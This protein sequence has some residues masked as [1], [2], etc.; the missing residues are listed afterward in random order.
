[1]AEMTSDDVLQKV[2]EAATDSAAKQY[3][4]Y[5]KT[6]VALDGK[7]QAAST[8][9][10]V[11]LGFIVAMANSGK[12]NAQLKD[13]VFLLVLALQIGAALY[14][15]LFGVLASRVRLV[16]VPYDAEAQIE[17]FKNLYAA[18]ADV[19]QSNLIAFHASRH[20][21]WKKS[22]ES[23]SQAIESKGCRVGHAQ[24]AAVA[25]AVLTVTALVVALLSK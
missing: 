23:M 21:Q 19:A 4:D 2:A 22:L 3:D 5:S 10:S 14:A 8:V 17:E 6:F 24:W 25:C 11:L 15:I 18:R 12:F 7:G 1:M 13:P 16:H 20:K 9:G